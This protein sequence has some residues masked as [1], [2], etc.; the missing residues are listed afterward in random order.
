M[1]PNLQRHSITYVRTTETSLEIDIKKKAVAE[2]S[3][4]HYMP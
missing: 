2:I 1:R 4:R 3:I